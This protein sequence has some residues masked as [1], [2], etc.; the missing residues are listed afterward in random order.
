MRMIPLVLA[1]LMVT[2]LAQ[3]E[4]PSS[5]R[6]DK[7][8]QNQAERIDQGVD[9]GELNKREAARMQRGQNRVDKVEDRAMA[10]GKVSARES[11]KLERIHDRQSARIV[12]QK[13]DAQKANRTR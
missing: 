12:H 10:D 2:A 3:A 11:R 9:S 13:H 7:R 4:S 1:G 8:Q 6:I 5:P